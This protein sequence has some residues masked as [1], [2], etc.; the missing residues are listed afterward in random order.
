M[1]FN[2][3]HS[4]KTQKAETAERTGEIESRAGIS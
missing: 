2:V 4:E 1:D 3:T